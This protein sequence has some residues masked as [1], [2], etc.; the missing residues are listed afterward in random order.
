M[1]LID[2]KKPNYR[3]KTAGNHRI[4]ARSKRQGEIE[5]RN[6]IHRQSRPSDQLHVDAQWQNHT[7]QRQKEN[8]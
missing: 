2:V 8:G 6:R 7:R 5:T 1:I 3:H 4:T